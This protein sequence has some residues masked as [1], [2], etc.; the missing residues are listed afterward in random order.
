MNEDTVHLDVE[1]VLTI[2]TIACGHEVDVRD[3]GLLASATMRPQA[4]VFGA[5]AYPTVLEKAAALLHSLV[6]NHA[7][8]DGNKRTAWTSAMVFLELNGHDVPG[9]VDVDA[10]E[11]LVLATARGEVDVPELARALAAL[12]DLDDAA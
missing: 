5:D 10:A 1:D 2:A 7:L 12:L 11:E 4:T 6:R 8:V 3:V 9:E